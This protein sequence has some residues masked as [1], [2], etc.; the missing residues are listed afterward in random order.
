MYHR[1]Q[2]L[3]LLQTKYQSTISGSALRVGVLKIRD[4]FLGEFQHIL[5]LLNVNLKCAPTS[6]FV[7]ADPRKCLFRFV[8][9]II[10]TAVFTYIE[11]WNLLLLSL[12]FA[13]TIAQLGPLFDSRECS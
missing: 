5:E 2:A 3:G 1:L 12:V 4:I 11:P 9:V 6:N 8:D 7:E 10:I 13:L